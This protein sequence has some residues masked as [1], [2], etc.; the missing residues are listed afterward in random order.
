MTLLREVVETFI[1]LVKA[2]IA[3]NA[4]LVPPDDVFEVT[5]VPCFILQGPTP[6]EDDARR[7]PAPLLASDQES[8]AFT[9]TARPRLYHLDFDIVATAGDARLSWTCRRRP[10]GSAKPIPRCLSATGARST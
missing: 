6:V 3:A 9:E 10:P 5:K 8:M 4:V 7:C 1:R 2:E